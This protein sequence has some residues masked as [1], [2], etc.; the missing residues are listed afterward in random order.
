MADLPIVPGQTERFTAT[1]TNADATPIDL[2][3]TTVTLES[4]GAAIANT[5]TIEDAAAGEVSVVIAAGVTEGITRRQ[6]VRFK[7]V[8]AGGDTYLEDW[9]WLV[10]S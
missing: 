2:T 10:P 6:R 3:G 4:D 5:V 1:F 7:R 8:V 9:F